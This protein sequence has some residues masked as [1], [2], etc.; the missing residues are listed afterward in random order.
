MSIYFPLSESGDKFLLRRCKLSNPECIRKRGDRLPRGKV[1]ARL[2][3]IEWS[4][5][6]NNFIRGSQQLAKLVAE[7]EKET[8]SK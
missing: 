7:I 2:S 5:H 3:K 6:G 4:T 1:W 8:T